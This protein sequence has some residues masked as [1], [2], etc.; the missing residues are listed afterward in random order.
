MPDRSKLDHFIK[1][2]K[3]NVFFYYID[4]IFDDNIY[5]PTAVIPNLT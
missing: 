1:Y 2:E 4:M 5:N 3:I